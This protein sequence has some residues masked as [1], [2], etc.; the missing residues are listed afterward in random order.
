MARNRITDWQ[1]VHLEGGILSWDI[2]ELIAKE[3][4]VASEPAAYGLP[5]N[6]SV[7]EAVGSAYSKA[8]GLYLDYL[9]RVRGASLLQSE[10][11]ITRDYVLR[12]MTCLGWSFS[13]VQKLDAGS[14]SY[15]IRRL[16]YDRIPLLTVA[17]N[18]S[19]DKADRLYAI[20]GGQGLISPFNMLQQYLSSSG[21]ARWG[22]L[23]NGEKIRL[24]RSATALSRPEYLE[25]DLGAI[26]AGDFYNEFMLL[27]RILHVSRVRND[28]D[29][30]DLEIWEEWRN[31][32]ITDGERVR[33]R[34]RDGVKAALVSLGN[35]F[36][37]ANDGLKDELRNGRLGAT[38]YYHE[39]LRLCYRIL[40]LSVLE[41]RYSPDGMRLVFDPSSIPAARETYERGYSLSRLRH[42]MR[43]TKY[44]TGTHHDLWEAM[45]IVFRSL[46]DGEA[47]LGLPALGG[48]FSNSSCQHLDGLQ[49]LNRDFLSAMESLRWSTNDDGLYWIDYRNLGSIELGS[50]YESLL[51]LVPVVD[52]ITLEFRFLD[53]ND[54]ETNAGNKRK[55]SGSYYTPDFLVDQ[56]I[57]TALMPVVEERIKDPSFAGAEEALLSMTVVDPAC[58]SGHFLIA[59][60]SAIATRLALI[61][62]NAGNVEGF[63]SAFRDVISR[64]IYGVDINPMA[65][66]LTKMSLWIEGYEPGK[67][68][69]FLD[70]HIKC[71]NSIVGVFDTN[72]LTENG[73]PKDA[74]KAF[75][76]DDKT[77]V[78]LLA[79]RNAKEIKELRTSRTSAVED[80]KDIFSKGQL[81]NQTSITSLAEGSIEEVRHK[82]ELY[83]K[84]MEELEASPE[85][86]AC[87][88]YI[89]AFYAPKTSIEEGVPTTAMIGR[90]LSNNLRQ[91]E[92]PV[93]A[94]VA[95]MA[96]CDAYFHWPL[97][98]PEVFAKGGFDVVLG[99]PPWD[100]VKVKDEEF[101][102]SRIAS[103]AKAQNA[104][105]RKAMI[106]KLAE[107]ESSDYEKSVYREY[108]YQLRQYDAQNRFLHVAGSEGGAYPLAGN[109]DVN[110][111]AIF[112][113]LAS[114][115]RKSTGAV[116]FVVPTGICTDDGT[117]ELFGHFVSEGLVQ[118]IYDFENGNSITTVGSDGKVSKDKPRIF[119]AVHASYKFSLLTLRHSDQPDFCFFL[120]TVKDLDDKRRHFPLSSEDIMLMNPNTRTLPLLR[121]LKDYE[122]MKKIYQNSV[123][124]WDESR[125]EGNV[126]RLSFMTMFHM[127]NDSNLFFS[128]PGLGRMPLYEGKFISQYDHRFNSY[129]GEMDSRGNPAESFC[130]S[131]QKANPDFEITPQYWVDEKEVYLRYSNAPKDIKDYYRKG[132]KKV[133]EGPSQ[134]NDQMQFDFT[135]Y[136]LGL[137]F[138]REED[139]VEKT[140]KDMTPTWCFAFRDIAR[141]TDTR[142]C[143]STIIPLSG[144][145]NTLSMMKDQCLDDAIVLNANLTALPFDY[146][147][148][149]KVG[150]THLNQFYF[151]QLPVIPPSAYTDEERDFVIETSKKLL[152]TTRKMAEIL[153]C[154]VTI[155]NDDE[156]AVLIARLD[157][158]YAMKYGLD[159]KDL[160]FILDP[161]SVMGKGYPTQTFPQVKA[162]DIRQFG[163]YRTQ[164]LVLEAWDE[165]HRD[166][167]WKS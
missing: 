108:R 156:R 114:K 62:D 57:S 118:S 6:T 131:A 72:V 165:L 98:F 100:K 47:K 16:A 91:E 132:I 83:R 120:H 158:F 116:G 26:L 34:L 41:E 110:L 102:A 160:E 23:A 150:G 67:P 5:R 136:Q 141:A 125:V 66:E 13:A 29:D 93:I 137:D 50:V 76:D 105:Q 54:E 135:D 17:G 155:W 39:L 97:E 53:G 46:E 85:N 22:I 63:R 43:S 82:S 27:Y 28:V 92:L 94:R 9:E 159:R 90:I 130:T 61:R 10:R 115:L 149:N 111:Y 129:E 71:G 79:A 18:N 148:R 84:Y 21:E 69:S 42:I 112:T 101:F 163:E 11:D 152:G 95:S 162:N 36:I 31:T 15:P 81:T 86:R 19:F 48:I 30:T 96:E 87:D 122:L 154:P 167:L 59:A 143:I 70:A 52:Q 35:G 58:G 32:S 49:L 144:V 134:A 161:E 68:L 80:T 44:R 127:S 14:C 3:K 77:V 88:A 8:R 60:A 64:C 166:G 104:A 78:K 145:G 7:K 133:S 139:S 56:L 12:I 124:V 45:V 126:F 140:V 38:E 106:R 33:D 74:F 65:V 147:A 153:S 121:S 119:P 2:L 117:K 89:A 99:N 73:I 51:E 25:F 123:V 107:A 55:T 37:H 1:H 157:A 142:T 128:G 4:A 40:F 138:T 24:M 164:R 75:E 146:V 20:R 113:E 109:G 151:K 103:I